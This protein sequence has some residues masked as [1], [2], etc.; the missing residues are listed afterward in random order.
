MPLHCLVLERFKY[1]DF[2]QG[3]VASH[4]RVAKPIT[5][6]FVADGDQ[7]RL[8]NVGLYHIRSYLLQLVGL[9]SGINTW[10]GIPMVMEPKEVQDQKRQAWLATQKAEPL[11][12]VETESDTDLEDET[13]VVYSWVKPTG[14]QEWVPETQ[15]SRM[16]RRLTVK[17]TGSRHVVSE[18]TESSVV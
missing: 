17:A 11:V 18:S 10:D 4:L 3:H 2:G 7:F 14:S 5:R 13:R 9:M 8:N 16:G 15:E 6:F 12:V 1:F